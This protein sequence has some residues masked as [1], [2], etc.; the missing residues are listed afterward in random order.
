M[1]QYSE[2]TEAKKR[3]RRKKKKKQDEKPPITPEPVANEHGCL[4]IGQPCRG[5]S[6][7][8]CSGQC[9]GVAPAQGQPDISVCVAH[10]ASICSPALN[11]CT[12]GNESFCHASNRNCHC[13]VTTGNAG[14]CGDFTLG[15]LSLC[16]VCNRDA[17]CQAEFG[18]GAACVVFEGICSGYC[19]STGGTACLPACP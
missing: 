5:D 9:E 4:D 10:N 12:T 16:R 17:D 8:C 15:A 14:F 18:A 1:L 13:T 19:P 11:I 7:L 6:T 3:H 2:N